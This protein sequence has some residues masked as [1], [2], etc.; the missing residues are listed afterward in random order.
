MMAHPQKN[1]HNQY[2]PTVNAQ[3]R[4]IEQ[5]VNGRNFNN[6]QGEGQ[7]LEEIDVGSYDLMLE[8][9]AS[10]SDLEAPSSPIIGEFLCD[11]S[12]VDLMER[13]YYNHTGKI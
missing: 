10:V 5:N 11:A 2:N 4:N 12:V 13:Q 1:G 7:A 8:H 3:F 9:E 6:D